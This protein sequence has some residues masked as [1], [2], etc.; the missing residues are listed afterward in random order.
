M[1]LDTA[2]KDNPFND[3]S[4]IVIARV[5]GKSIHIIDDFRARLKIPELKAKT[6]ELAR[7]HNAHVLLIED[8][9][10]GH[11]LIQLLQAEEPAGVP[12]PIARRPKGDKNS[13]VFG[14]SA[15]IQAGRMFVPEK[16]HWVAEYT[17]ELLGFPGAA[18]D[19]QVDATSQLLLW[20]LEKDMYRLPIN[21]GPILMEAEDGGVPYSAHWDRDER[22]PWGAY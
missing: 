14:A 18:F 20:V 10:S 1:S 5:L 6:I 13:R 9:V 12:S 8:A 16:A 15:L 21:E 17:G 3:F 19:D 11:A 22:D 7:L 2:S 4:V